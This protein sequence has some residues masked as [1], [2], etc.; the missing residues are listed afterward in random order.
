MCRC[1]NQSILP[2]AH[3]FIHSA[4]HI[5]IGVYVRNQSWLRRRPCKT[6]MQTCCIP[7]RNLNSLWL[8]ESAY[9]M[10]TDFNGCHSAVHTLGEMTMMG[11]GAGRVLALSLPFLQASQG[12]WSLGSRQCLFSPA[13]LWPRQSLG[14][15]GHWRWSGWHW[16]RPEQWLSP[17]PLG[18]PC[19]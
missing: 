19:A 5:F 3:S 1:E 2:F 16:T 6:Q 14:S 7:T 13:A 18:S 15:A 4:D 8:K 12:A 9:R 11:R 10:R 17:C